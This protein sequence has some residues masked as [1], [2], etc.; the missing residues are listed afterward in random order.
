MPQ[1]YYINEYR[2][3]NQRL[4]TTVKGSKINDLYR[5]FVYADKG[6]EDSTLRRVPAQF[7]QYKKGTE[8]NATFDWDSAKNK[9]LKANRTDRSHQEDDVI[10]LGNSLLK[11]KK[12]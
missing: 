11:A 8:N 7:I 10:I 3:N 12:N 9:N 6:G 1:G 4:G 2:A 5:L